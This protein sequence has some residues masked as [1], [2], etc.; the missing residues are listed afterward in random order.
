MFSYNYPADSASRPRRFVST[1]SLGKGSNRDQQAV[2][3]CSAAGEEIWRSGIE[4]RGACGT[5][6]TLKAIDPREDIEVAGHRQH[7]LGH[8]GAEA[9]DVPLLLAVE[10]ELAIEALGRV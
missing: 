8:A 2:P 1:Q 3:D 6:T 5:A 4:G 9:L 10:A 7:V